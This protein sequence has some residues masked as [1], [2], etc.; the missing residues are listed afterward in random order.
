MSIRSSSCTTTTDPNT[1]IA[2]QA[3]SPSSRQLTTDREHRNA[4]YLCIDGGGT[5]TNVSISGR[6]GED[7]EL[8]I[9]SQGQERSSN[10][11]GVGLEQAILSIGEATM[12]ALRSLPDGTGSS[13]A[14]GWTYEGF[15]SVGCA[16]RPA[17]FTRIWA[18]LSGV[19]GPEDHRLLHAGLTN[20]F[21]LS[22]EPTKLKLTN[23]CD[24]LC[25]AIERVY[26]ANHRSP[27]L[28]CLGGIVLI[29]G[30]G[31]IATAF[32]PSTPPPQHP[33]GP[34]ESLL[35]PLGRMGGYGYLLGDEG[36]SYYVGL[37]TIKELLSFFDRHQEPRTIW[38]QD[39]L[40]ASGQDRKLTR[41]GKPMEVEDQRI[42]SSSLMGPVLAHFEIERLEELL[43]AVYSIANEHER[44]VRIAELSRLVMRAAFEGPAPDGFA[45]R[46]LERA[47]LRLSELVCR[48][49]TLYELLPNQSVLCL[50][51]GMWSYTQFRD[52][53]IHTMRI[54]WNAHWGWVETIHQPDQVAAL[55]F[56]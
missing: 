5:K 40:E 21:G 11:T 46:I 52:L 41:R 27:D 42:E 33:S 51:G 3:E 37:E 14:R 43:A 9:L 25:S 55:S 13:E 45:R 34:S 24:L 15:Q 50:G 31:S 54:N 20:L 1:P 10:Y 36:S 49:C 16:F 19:D 26:K 6:S 56:V 32:G 23:D 47:G 38:S 44:K 29:A 8:R 30:T 48:L 53:V 39:S 22:G 4:L 28:P 18:G 2:S 35:E 17:P 7:G 12:S